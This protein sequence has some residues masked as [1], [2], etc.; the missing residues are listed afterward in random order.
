MVASA[1][2]L[3]L[4]VLPSVASAPSAWAMTEVPSVAA[5]STAVSSAD[6]IHATPAAVAELVT[7]SL[8][9]ITPS[10]VLPQAAV[11]ISGT[12]RN[13]GSVS[14][15]SALA[16]VFIGEGPLVG[17][18]AV[19]EWA[20]N[21]GERS[22]T[23]VA[24]TSLGPELA[25][26][27]VATF[28]LTVPAPAISHRES[29]AIL[30]VRV[31]VVGT[32]SEGTQDLASVHTF[33]PTLSSIKAYEPL[34]IAWLVP[35][36]L[37]P[38]PALHGMD[39]LARTAAWT[40]A[41]GRGSRLDRLIKGTDS[42]KITWA[43]D[44]AILGPPRGPV[45]AADSTTP[46]P[47]P[48]PST[49]PTQG[50]AAPPADPV[51]DATTALAARLRAAAPRHTL[52]S[53]P[54]A[55]PDLDAVLPL[56]A[57]ESALGPVITQVST[58]SSAVGSA[59]T[60]IAWP[61]TGKLAEGGE[62]ELKAAFSSPG[63]GAAVIAAS[64]LSSDSGST[65]NASRKSGQGL[66]LLAYDDAL[67]RTF[68]Q[69][70]STAAGAITIQR[71]LADTMAL[72]GERPGTQNRSVLVAAPRTFAGDPSVLTAFFAAIAQAK[73]LIPTSTDQFLAASTSA[74]PEA[75]GPSTTVSPPSPAA[76]PTGSP[77]G[78]P[79]GAP[80]A[81]D[82]LSPAASPLTAPLL[83]R[84]PRTKSAIIGV[85]SIR[86]DAQL[87]QERWTDAQNQVLSVRWRGHGPGLVE[88]DKATQVAIGTVSR[89]V[90]VAPSSVNFFA[91][92]GVLQITVVNDLAVPVH[93]VHLTLT[94][95]QPR[96]RIEEQPGP[97]KIGAKSRTNVPL[98][99]T[100]IAA[101]LVPI[102][103]VLT[104]ANGTPLGQNARVDVRVQPTSTW[105]YWVL[106]S[107]AG[108]IL[109][110][111]SYRSLRRGS[112]RAARPAEQEVSLDV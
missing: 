109:V 29:F 78:S 94:P 10:I 40:S 2:P 76:A 5:A 82:P 41:I 75:P 97:L 43:I 52:W 103:A 95:G 70:S 47:T 18:E 57:G 68:A 111:G 102:S 53:L 20:T 105:V 15:A 72:L 69:T 35:L 1:A 106:G 96:L 8:K 84:I 80:T 100:A 54:Y 26:G 30:P 67:S 32:T 83:G 16:R 12:V 61:V 60:D 101:G 11:T 33:L 99:V 17:R 77:T 93:D 49:T 88:L 112:T 71:F 58:L 45:P 22:V 34:A 3:A 24:R 87:F 9:S 63:L 31:D 42:T 92:K 50:G 65:E 86:D 44:P 14:I 89:G 27:A 79:T 6:I 13:V 73:W 107:A 85:A 74:T 104:S 110:L 19:S 59:R 37:D 90:S 51:A 28:T 56:P 39:S 38:D 66:P 7:V 108:V 25:P 4:C 48:S 81:R 91:D 36:T 62:Q 98:R 55:D 46:S 23:E 21:T 64:T